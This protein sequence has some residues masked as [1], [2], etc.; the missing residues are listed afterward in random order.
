MFM[1]VYATA[2]LYI[3]HYYVHYVPV[4]LKREKK[5]HTNKHRVHIVRTRRKGRRRNNGSLAARKAKQERGTR[6]SKFN[7]CTEIVVDVMPRDHNTHKTD[8]QYATKR[9]VACDP[10]ASRCVGRLA[11]VA[12]IQ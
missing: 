2:V 11:R 12:D 4:E 7:Y 1:V 6:G 10:V 8:T 5:K 3:M 9:T